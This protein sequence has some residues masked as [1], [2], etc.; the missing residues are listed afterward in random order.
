MRES[1]SVEIME[2]LRDLGADIHYSDPHIP[3]F[4]ETREHDFDLSSVD[5]TAQS[6]AGFD[7]VVLTTDHKAFDY[8]LIL[9]HAAVILD[10]RGKF[11]RNHEKV[12]PA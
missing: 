12:F 5:L 8:D 7:A 9:E 3:V 2:K 10:T 11:D 1:P 6:L 4:P